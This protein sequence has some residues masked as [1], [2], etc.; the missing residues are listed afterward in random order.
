MTW[1]WVKHMPSPKWTPHTFWSIGRVLSAWPDI[2]LPCVSACDLVWEKDSHCYLW[3]LISETPRCQGFETLPARLSSTHCVMTS[4]L[5]S[6]N[7]LP[8][9]VSVL[10]TLQGRSRRMCCVPWTSRCWTGEK[11]WLAGGELCGWFRPC[12]EPGL[13]IYCTSVQPLMLTLTELRWKLVRA[14]PGT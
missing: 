1:P 10:V 8:F 2:F 7:P 6:P 3:N 14:W 5:Y 11:T 12:G 4:F 9:P 13:I